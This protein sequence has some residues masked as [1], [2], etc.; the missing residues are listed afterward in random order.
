[1][2]LEIVEMGDLIFSCD[3]GNLENVVAE[4]YCLALF[5]IK[6]Q[7]KGRRFHRRQVIDGDDV[8]IPARCFQKR[9]KNVPAD[10]A[11]CG[12][13]LWSIENHEK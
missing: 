10:P 12:N 13:T 7:E 5:G 2:I 9:P 1:M 4:I 6:F 3:A 8:E 11:I